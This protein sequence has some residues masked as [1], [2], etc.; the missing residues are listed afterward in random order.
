MITSQFRISY[1]AVILEGERAPRDVSD[2][3][4]AAL[5]SAECNFKTIS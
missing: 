4:F 3:I 1:E 5:T 2:K